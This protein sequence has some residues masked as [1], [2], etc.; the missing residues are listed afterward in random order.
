[1]E[2]EGHSVKL[3]EIINDGDA[4]SKDECDLM[5]FFYPVW[6]SEPP[7]PMVEFREKM[8]EVDGKKLFLVG[9]CAAF[10]GDTGVH[11]KKIMDKKGYDVFYLDHIIMPTNINIPWLPE[12]YW[13]RVP[14]EDELKKILD[15]AERKLNK[16]CK[17]IL[18]G[19]NKIEGTG[20][21]ARLGGTLQREF[22]WTADGYK[23]HFS[24]NKEKCIKCGLCRKICPTENISISEDGDISFGKKCILCVKCFNLCP[25]NAILIC[26]KS[27]DDKKYRR[28]KGPQKGFKPTIYRQ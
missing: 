19:E 15:K 10:T 5:G 12:N 6:G 7:D 16:V 28:Y 17:A 11:W 27:I 4:F 26:E 14:L 9:N 8:P 25:V 23:S 20:P 18:N 1:M 13:K 3:Y 24:A 21:I 22:Y 2:Q